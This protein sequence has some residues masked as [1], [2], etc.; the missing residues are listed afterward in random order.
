MPIQI[1]PSPTSFRK[2][3]TPYSS[4]LLDIQL[5]QTSTFISTSANVFESQRH[6]KHYCQCHHRQFH[7]LVQPLQ[8]ALHQGPADRRQVQLLQA[9]EQQGPE[10]RRRMDVMQQIRSKE[11]R[12]TSREELKGE[13]Q[14]C[15]SQISP[16]LELSS[17][18]PVQCSAASQP[19]DMMS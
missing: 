7:C 11:S 9:A 3:L 16:A 10:H 17:S 4:W 1:F 19:Y 6:R 18:P 2:A 8:G 14:H 13:K 12:K 15:V 5:K